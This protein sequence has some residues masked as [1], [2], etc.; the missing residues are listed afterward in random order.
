MSGRF[1]V[2]ETRA[3]IAQLPQPS[4]QLTGGRAE[5]VFPIEFFVIL[6]MTGLMSLASGCIGWMAV[7]M[8]SSIE[9]RLGRGEA[10]VKDLRERI[11]NLSLKLSSEYVHHEDFTRQAMLVNA[12]MEK[13]AEQN[14]QLLINFERSRKA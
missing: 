3:V 11:H 2:Q 1:S 9:G 8:I 6:A 5:V 13:L 10:E 4:S 14:A 12:G 7:R